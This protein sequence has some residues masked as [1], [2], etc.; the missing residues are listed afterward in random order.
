MVENKTNNLFEKIKKIKLNKKIIISSIIILALIIGGF[1]F[2]RSRQEKTTSTNTQTLVAAKIQDLKETVEISGTVSN[3]NYTEV[4]TQAIGTVTQVYVKEGET[5]KAGDKLFELELSPE[6]KEAYQDAY[7][8]YLSAKTNLASAENK[9]NSLQITLFE[10]NQYFL[11]HADAEDLAE[12]DPTYI[13][14]WAAWKAAENDYKNQ[15]NVIVQAKAQVSSAYQT[16]QNMSSTVTAPVAGVV[17][18]ITAVPGLV[19]GSVNTSGSGTSLSDRMATI[20]TNNNLLASFSLSSSDIAKVEIGQKVT[21][22][23]NDLTGSIISVDRYGTTDTTTSYTV[24]A[25][26]DSESTGAAELLPNMTV[27]GEIAISEQLN[28]LTIPTLA[29]STNDK[30]ESTVKVKNGNQTE[31]R[32]VTTGVTSGNLT[33]ILTGLSEGEQVVFELS[34]FSST[35][36]TNQQNNSFGGGAMMM[37]GSSGGPPSGGG[38][39]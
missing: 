28:A 6:G 37:S 30:D 10:K 13:E 17:E 4:T 19:F 1:F 5:V 26:F 39:R 20:K 34:E 23:D 11:N 38:M 35:T 3:A 9:L 27:D 14:Q 2:W 32:T 18:N 7:A 24:I 12:N 21:L 8:S 22:T 29:I 15:A 16:Y 31:T 25:Q 36:T 33:Q